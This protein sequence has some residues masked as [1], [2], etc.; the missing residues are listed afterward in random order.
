MATTLNL[1]Y[2][3][4]VRQVSNGT[5]RSKYAY[6]AMMSEN[7]AALK[8]APWR[9]A[10]CGPNEVTTTVNAVADTDAVRDSD[11][12]IT[13]PASYRTYLRDCYDAYKQGGDAILS[14]GTMCG[15]AGMVAYRFAVPAAVS[16]QCTSIVLPLFRD[17]YCRSGL[18]IVAVPSSDETPSEDWDVVR[19]NGANAIVSASTPESTID[20]VT[21]WGALGQ[22]DVEYLLASRPGEGTVEFTSEVF[23]AMRQ[24][25]TYAYIWVYVSIE[26]YCDYWAIYSGNTPRYYSIEGS[27]MLVARNAAFTF[28]GT[29]E[30]DGDTYVAAIPIIADTVRQEWSFNGGKVS[31][32]QMEMFGSALRPFFTSAAL[33]TDFGLVAEYAL[34]LD[35]LK[36]KVLFTGDQNPIGETTPLSTPLDEIC[37]VGGIRLPVSLVG[38]DYEPEDSSVLYHNVYCAVENHADQT[39]SGLDG[40]TGNAFACSWIVFR[41]VP[42]CV[43]AGK[44]EYSKMKISFNGTRNITAGFACDLLVWRSTSADVFGPFSSAAVAALAG[45]PVFFTGSKS[46][47]SGSFTGD[48]TQHVTVTATASLCQRIDM[49]A[50]TASTPSLA[51]DLDSPV[52]PGDAL[53]FVLTPKRVTRTL[54]QSQMS[55][56]CDLRQPE[57]SFA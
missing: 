34:L 10:E 24:Q 35:R 2:V 29:F 45:T 17:R 53:I 1:P 18:R 41:Y 48:G 57:I 15:Y 30:A 54:N 8:S 13:R 26:D 31:S 5:A 32:A 33:F 42:Y 4:F 11:G 52:F 49:S 9:R 46:S 6:K 47:V 22:G 25:A 36:G 39:R 27:A 50:V 3:R 43:P 23:A 55:L 37:M 40:T 19:G 56:V 44:N 16:G 7:L 14:E 51:I 21:S 28:G 38:S 20:G 12:N